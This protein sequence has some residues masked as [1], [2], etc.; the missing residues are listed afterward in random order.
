MAIKSIKTDNLAMRAALAAS[1]IFCAAVV[2]FFVRWCAA[3]AMAQNTNVL[4]VSDWA[5]SL[6]PHDP[7]THYTAA[8]LREKTF[9]PA[10]SVRS[11]DE[12]ERTAALAPDDFRTWLALGRAR[13]HAGDAAGAE[14]ALRR[15]LEA[16]PH[17]SE[18]K[19][20]LGNTLLRQGK[21]D[22]AFAEMRGAA[23][24]DP[25]RYANPTAAIVWQLFDGDSAQVKRF[26]GDSAVFKAPLM[27]RLTGEKRFAE[28][29]E[30]WA[31]LN[32]EQKKTAFL[33]N[34]IQL[35]TNAL[36]VGKYRDALSIWEQTNAED[37]DAEK[38]YN[39]GFE[40]DVKAADASV[41]DWR[42]DAGVQ[43]QISLDDAQKH[44]GARS[45]V[46]VFNSP[47]GR[48]F[49][50]VSQ[51]IVVEPG[52]KYAFE[53]FYK[54]ELKTTATLLWQVAAPDGKVLAATPAI[55]PVAGWTNLRIEFTVP[56]KV[57]AIY[58]RPVRETCRST[59]CPISGRVWFDDFSLQ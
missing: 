21:R 17:Y 25:A 58:I 27:N 54:S 12:Y 56:D 34:G 55:A 4:E 38:I 2:F 59:L 24:G 48:E 9:V 40:A 31:S 28:A 8:V 20:I 23:E 53:M 26:L 3:N 29:A 57:D 47:T 36:E 46:A 16:A 7:Q 45:L 14:R 33:D 42:I 19:W 43:P 41:F 35:F 49:R 1:M 15:A 52:K 39:G 11:L 13:E 32:D 5:I 6:A 22:E 51:A 18:V 30:I 10:D 37:F 50:G 44:G